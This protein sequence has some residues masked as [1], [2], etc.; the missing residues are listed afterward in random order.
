MAAGAFTK[1]ELSNFFRDLLEN[2]NGE[3]GKAGYA[4]AAMDVDYEGALSR[5]GTTPVLLAD[6]DG[7]CI[8]LSFKPVIMKKEG[9]AVG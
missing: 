9:E 1:E 5:D 8:K 6:K 2:M 4:L 7:V 3:C